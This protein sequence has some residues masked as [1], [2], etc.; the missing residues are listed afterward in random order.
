[1]CSRSTFQTR[2]QSEKEMACTGQGV[3]QVLLPTLE[4]IALTGTA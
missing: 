1:M 4:I 3:L 2:S